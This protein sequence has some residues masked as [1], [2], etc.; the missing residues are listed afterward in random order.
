MNKDLLRSESQL[1]RVLELLN[2]LEA[3]K[4]HF[5]LA[6]NQEDAITIEIAVPGQRWEIDCYANGRKDVEVF[7]S[8]GSIR[9]ASAIDELFSDFSD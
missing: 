1:T 5:R 3:A 9:D 6:Y 7:K 8:D 2:R 4:I